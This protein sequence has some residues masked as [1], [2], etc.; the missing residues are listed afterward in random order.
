MAKIVYNEHD[1]VTLNYLPKI[2][3]Y[4]EDTLRQ[5]LAFDFVPDEMLATEAGALGLTSCSEEVFRAESAGSLRRR[6]RLGSLVPLLSV[7]SRLT[8]E[9]L[10]AS[11]VVKRERD[12]DL[13]VDEVS[14]NQVLAASFAILSALVDM[15]LVKVVTRTSG[16]DDE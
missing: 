3:T 13:D 11:I 14:Q 5:M 2:D 10:N 1:D 4:T 6:R 9:V 7:L 12:T 15:G 8:S 16:D